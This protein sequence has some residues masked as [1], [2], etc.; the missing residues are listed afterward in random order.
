MYI[1]MRLE[2][3]TSFWKGRK[4]LVRK[5]GKV[6]HK[7]YFFFIFSQCFKKPFFFSLVKSLD[8]IMVKTES[9]QEPTFN[10]LPHN[11]DFYL[12][13]ERGLL[14][15]LWEKKK[16]LVTSIFCFPAMFPTHHKTNF[17]F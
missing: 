17:S 12:L 1:Y 14:K 9:I 8:H 5:G 3:F 2:N 10:S 7:H 11:S 13:S 6:C 15:L 16:M 4:H